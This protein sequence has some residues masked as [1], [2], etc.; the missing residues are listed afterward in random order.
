M[1]ICTPLCPSW[2]ECQFSSLGE[3]CG[4][5]VDT[6]FGPPLLE[7]G[8]CQDATTCE[9]FGPDE[10]CKFGRTVET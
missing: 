10:V 4:D 9:E 3:A 6:M 5:D 2:R 7:C 1:N 8:K